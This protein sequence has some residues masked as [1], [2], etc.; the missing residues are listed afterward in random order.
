MN[1]NIVSA[2][3]LI[4]AAAAGVLALCLL[5]QEKRFV[6]HAVRTSG[7]V[8]GNFSSGGRGTDGSCGFVCG[9]GWQSG[10]QKLRNAWA[11]MVCPWG[12]EVAILYTRKK[13]FG[14]VFWNI[15]VERDSQAKPYRVYTFY[16]VILGMIALGLAA[17]GIFVLMR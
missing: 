17:A 6:R 3:F 16:G 9:H 7:Y 15:F 10:H 1:I 13:R 2:V 12:D 14:L 8:A 11:R 4:C 5:N